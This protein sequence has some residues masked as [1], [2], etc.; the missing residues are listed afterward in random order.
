MHNSLLTTL[1]ATIQNNKFDT[2]P[3]GYAEVTQ[4]IIKGILA[5]KN[6]S[7]EIESLQIQLYV[8]QPWA[9]QANLRL[10]RLL[11]RVGDGEVARLGAGS[12]FP[13][14]PVFD[15]KKLKGLR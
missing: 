15:S 10:D 12:Q 11:S 9:A 13:D 1:E 6:I 4:G 14:T 7:N 2:N 5:C 3:D 8:T